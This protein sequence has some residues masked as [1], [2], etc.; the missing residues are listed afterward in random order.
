M[1]LAPT[2]RSPTIISVI[3]RP[4]LGLVHS[5]FE[6]SLSPI[7]ST[8]NM[9]GTEYF[10]GYDMRTLQGV[11]RTDGLTYVTAPDGRVITVV[12]W[13]Q[14]PDGN[15]SS[16]MINQLVSE[17]LAGT[18][19]WANKVLCSKCHDNNKHVL[20]DPKPSILKRHL[21]AHFDLKYYACLTCG[22]QFTTKD[23][24][25]FHVMSQHLESKDR[26]AA[27]GYVFALDP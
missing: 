10:Q 15:M 8:G 1:G 24:G 19:G 9:S 5:T 12:A 7:I 25:V 11:L 6:L 26:R 17:F 3:N 16:E 23:Q 4:K 18:G 27:E 20:W 14:I 2:R 13:L 21:A 22:H